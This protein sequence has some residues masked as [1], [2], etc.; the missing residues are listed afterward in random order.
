MRVLTRKACIVAAAVWLVAAPTQATE[1]FV[2]PGGTGNGTSGAP[3]GRVQDGLNAALP[4]DAITV[5]PG[6][7]NESVRTVRNGAAGSPI[8]LRAELERGSVVLTANGTVLRVDH[9]YIQVEGLVLDGQYAADDTVD[10]NTGADFL[11]LRNLEIR[12]SSKDLIDIGS[13][14]GVLIEGCLIHHALNAA[15]GRTDA[16]GIAAS[17]VRNF[18]IRDTE[19][20]TFSGDG[21]QVD[22][23]RLAPGWMDVTVE[24]VY[25]WLAPLPV[26]ENG[27][28]A[29]T[30]PGENAIDT[31]ASASLPRSTIVIRDTT[32]WGFRDGLI[33][34]MAAFN[35]KENIDATVDGVTV[36]DSE[37][38]FRLRGP[39]SAQS[40]GAWVTVKN[41][42]VYNTTSA[43]RYEDNITNLKIWNSTI[44][45]G[46]TRPFR[47]AESN[48]EALEVR[49]VL[50]RGALPQEASHPSN[51]SVGPEAFVD[52]AA[53][54]YGLAP[55]ASAIDAG[56]AIL[57]VKTD[58]VGTTRPQERGYDVGAYEWTAPLTQ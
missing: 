57:E 58:R 27:F 45:N 52:D 28:A 8:R 29:G 15:N 21:F 44:G 22:P 43:F 4:G 50:V 37:I 39:G 54:N 9:A 40:G 24:R 5:R 14:R 32:A 51:R 26:A 55:G 53:N 18:T 46:V 47:A 1:W 19:I 20:H 35:L 12:R 13:P 30:V 16:H 23:G 33:N 2:A 36:Y 3:F 56:I 17:A 31:K 48:S 25:F 49:N 10:V 41:A 42:V 6:T 7:Y 38:A 11:V 34:N